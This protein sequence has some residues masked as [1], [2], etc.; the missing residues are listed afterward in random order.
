[1]PSLT[2]YGQQVCVYDDNRTFLPGLTAGTPALEGGIANIAANLEL[3]DGATA[4]LSK[5][6]SVLV[7]NDPPGGGYAGAVAI[8]K[9]VG[10]WVNPSAA[11]GD[12]QTVLQNKVFTATG[13]PMNTVGGAYISDGDDNVLAY[14]ERSSNITLATNDTI[15]A[16]QL[17]IRII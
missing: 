5:N 11:S 3:Y 6:A 12:T 16:D 17:T 1:M 10:D 8:T 7:L 9:G 2:N 14:W 13:N 15:T 4:V